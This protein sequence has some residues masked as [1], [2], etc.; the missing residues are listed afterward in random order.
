MSEVL[1]K[2]YI[3][4]ADDFSYETAI[5]DDVIF[6]DHV[7]QYEDGWERYDLDSLASD[8]LSQ[9]PYEPGF[10]SV[11]IPDDNGSSTITTFVFFLILNPLLKLNL[12]FTRSQNIVSFLSNFPIS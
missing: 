8:E 12:P 9:L 10:G 3:I 4:I 2:T 1:D 5:R 11:K 7:A 6:Y